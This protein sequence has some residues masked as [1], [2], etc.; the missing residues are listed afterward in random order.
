MRH[1]LCAGLLA[2]AA[3]PPVQNGGDPGNAPAWPGVWGPH[4]NG[5]A[6]TAG[7]PAQPTGFKELWRHKTQGG[8]SEVVVTGI[9]VFTMEARDGS[10]DVVALEAASGRERWRAKVGPTYRGHDGSHDGPIATPAVDGTD[11]FALGPH[12]VLVALDAATGAE[13][14]RHDLV[15]E[16]GAIAMIYGFG[17]SPLIEGRSVIVQTGGEKGRGLLAFD[18]ATGKLLWNAPHGLRGG[19]AS[20][21]IGTLAGARQIIAAAGDRV[22]AVSPAD[23]TLLWSVA[24]PG[25]GESVANPPQLLP[26]DRVLITFWG[27]AVLLKVA[28]QGQAFTATELWRSPRLRAAYSPTIYRDGNLYGFNGPFLTCID[29]ATGDVRW[30]HRM[31]EGALIGLGS[32]LLVLGRASGNLHVVQISPTAFIE[33]TRAAVLTP[34][35]TSM[36]GPSVAGR[37]LFVRN[38]EEVVALSVEG[39]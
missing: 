25:D 17:T 37:R 27:E 29:A 31:Y 18:R 4:R 36:T 35:A 15:K 20:P 24:G 38:S 28:R 1:F 13:R 3:L 32:H 14:W 5:T 22:Y 19:Y 16:F 12:G 34:G 23:G 11:L 39:K 10:D 21:S 26:D 9:G 30:R 6:S 33:V 2:V 8:Y 7:I